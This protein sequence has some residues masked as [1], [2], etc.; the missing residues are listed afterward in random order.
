[1]RF[2]EILKELGKNLCWLLGTGVN[3]LGKGISWCGVK[4]AFIGTN[5]PE[6]PPVDKQKI[7]TNDP[8]PPPIDG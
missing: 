7:G 1:M 3:Y 4:V 8:E 5:D 6:P 2:V